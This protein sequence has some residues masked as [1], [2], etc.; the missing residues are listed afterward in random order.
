MTA[1]TDAFEEGIKAKKTALVM[2]YAPWSVCMR[3]F[4]LTLILYIC[5]VRPL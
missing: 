5:Q 3:A 4:K 2:L 1:G